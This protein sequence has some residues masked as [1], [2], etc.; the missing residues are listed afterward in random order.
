MPQ[1]IADKRCPQCYSLRFYRIYRSWW[2][3]LMPGSRCY[4]CNQCHSKFI[5][6]LGRSISFDPLISDKPYYG[7]ERRTGFDRRQNDIFQFADCRCGR[8]RR[9]KRP[10]LKRRGL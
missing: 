7:P 3:R 5:K 4:K 10:V 6:L 9:R 8:D 2:M 1:L